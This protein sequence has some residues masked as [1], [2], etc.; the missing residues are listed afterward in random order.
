MEQPQIDSKYHKYILLVERILNSFES[1]NEWADVIAFL[2][3]LLKSFQAYPQYA[4]VPHK[5]VVAKRL[6]Q[7]L[8]PALPAG[9]HQKTLEVYEYI[10]QSIGSGQLEEDLHLYSY[11]LFPFLQNASTSVKT[12]LLKIFEKH[13]L[14]L[15]KSLSPC[16][17][18]FI[19]ALLPGLEEERTELFEKV[20]A[21][22]DK[23]SNVVGP[24][25]FYQAMWLC[26]ISAPQLRFCAIN[27]LTQRMPKI[28]SLE[29]VAFLL[30]NDTG[31]MVR[32]ISA[33][34]EDKDILVQRGILELLVNGFPLQSQIFEEENLKILMSHAVGVVLRKD[35]SLNRRLYTWLLGPGEQKQQQEYF[36]TYSKN[37]LL[38]A[39]KEMFFAE[40]A[41]VIDLQRPYKVL[42]SLMDKWEIG[43][44]I[45]RDLL[46]DILSSL[47]M[48]Y[49]GG[50]EE[51]E[52]YQTANMFISMVEPRLFWSTL[53]TSLT[54]EMDVNSSVILNLVDFIVNYVSFGDS[55]TLRIHFPLFLLVLLHRLKESQSPEGY[56]AQLPHKQSIIKTCL[57]LIKNMSPDQFREMPLATQNGSSSDNEEKSSNKESSPSP[58]IANSSLKA[59][60]DIIALAEKIYHEGRNEDDFEIIGGPSLANMALSCIHHTYNSILQ[61][62][63]SSKQEGRFAAILKELAILCL[64]I[65]DG[66]EADSFIANDHI[67]QI[68]LFC[69]QIHDLPLLDLVFT[70]LYKLVKTNRCVD[71]AQVQENMFLERFVNE[72]WEFLVPDHVW[73]HSR[74]VELIWMAHT[75]S[76]DHCLPNAV[77]KL[78]TPQ[79]IQARIKAFEIFSVFWSHSVDRHGS[80]LVLARSLLVVLGSLQDDEPRISRIA[81][82]WI[83][84]HVFA[85]QHLHQSFLEILTM[86]LLDPYLSWISYEHQ[87]G[88]YTCHFYQYESRFDEAQVAYGFHC[89]KMLWKLGGSSFLRVLRNTQVRNETLVERSKVLLDTIEELDHLSYLHIVVAASLRFLQSEF[90]TEC[91]EPVHHLNY[92]I[93][94]ACTD[95]LFLFV[96]HADE[97]DSNLACTIRDVLFRKLLQTIDARNFE[98]QAYLLPLLYIVL[99]LA[100]LSRE[101]VKKRA[102]MPQISHPANP[103][104]ET[105]E[106]DDLVSVEHED[107]AP[108]P[109]ENH[110]AAG[111]TSPHPISIFTDV[112]IDAI[113]TQFNSSIIYD[114]FHFIVVT[115]PCIDEFTT[116]VVEALINCICSQITMVVEKLQGPGQVEGLS[117]DAYSISEQIIALLEGLDKISVYALNGSVAW[118]RLFKS[119]NREPYIEFWDSPYQ[120]SNNTTAN[121][122]QKM[123]EVVL[124]KLFNIHDILY[125]TWLVVRRITQDEGKKHD[126]LVTTA[127]PSKN[128]ICSC[129]KMFLFRL[130]TIQPI[131][132]SEA[133]AGIWVL[134]NLSV[135]SAETKEPIDNTSIELFRSLP[136]AK[137][138]FVI[139]TLLE[140]VRKRTATQHKGKKANDFSELNSLAI[141]KYLESYCQMEL[142]SDASVD[143]WNYCIRFAREYF[144]NPS[145]HKFIFPHILRLLTTV[146]LKLSST[147]ISERKIHR[148]ARDVYQRI[149]D[150]SILL[151]GKLFSLGMWSRKSTREVD[152]LVDQYQLQALQTKYTRDLSDKIPRETEQFLREREIRMFQ[153]L[154]EYIATDV[155]PNLNNL[156][157]EQDRITTIF[158]NLV[159]YIISPVLKSPTSHYME[160]VLD[161]L[162][163]ASRNSSTYK[164]WRKE[165]WDY[166]MDTQFFPL[167]PELSRKWSKMIQSTISYEKER[168]AEVLGKI[169]ASP[170]ALFSSKEQE[171]LNRVQMLRRLSFIIFSGTHDQY[172]SILPTIQE[173]LVELVKS[174]AE[175]LVHVE[176]YLCLRVLLVR[177][178][179]RHL[180]NFWP[181]LLTELIR[182]FE[183]FRQKGV[184][185]SL[186]CDLMLAAC[187]FLDLVFTLGTDEF[188]IHQWIFI[189]DGVD[190]SKVSAA[191]HGLLEKIDPKISENSVEMANQE[192][193]QVAELTSTSLKS[194]RPMLHMRRITKASELSFFVKYIS[195]HVYQDTYSLNKPDISF[196]EKLIENDLIEHDE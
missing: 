148:E 57:S 145:G 26:M 79:T 69:L 117:L 86:V 116:H 51:S 61:T 48:H 27:F 189:T 112:L 24:V 164:I 141:I 80:H 50:H 94:R 152:D 162:L 25:S 183:M 19:L 72:L 179:P 78:L 119:K 104:A 98:L 76:S 31:L 90:S 137:P 147:I 157:G 21:L 15:E 108:R 114:W 154:M 47:K 139:P 64:T 9:V 49:D 55:E 110:K 83:R 124:Q 46:I 193:T 109:T 92:D 127:D 191:S 56:L 155:I 23:L 160:A 13:Y 70:F 129:L 11:G 187:K 192:L 52:L 37:I 87:H 60:E 134:N 123:R 171:M 178:A 167:Y 93:Q 169:T 73:Q 2:G 16:L 101:S 131:E 96:S 35:M 32:A 17:K 111:R 54:N 105:D 172:L 43:Y 126:G 130:Y 176:I 14:P 135:I 4:F 28:T 136:K 75:L 158:S 22:L 39:M 120:F 128:K 67:Q 65:V 185:N 82:S 175:E 74:V 144:H 113:S 103:P 42:I 18:S 34:L 85:H 161:I 159:Y 89:I 184:E 140:S 118:D 91:P 84:S 59:D 149:L 36:E 3:R 196:I 133:F 182:L 146:Y 132:V 53:Y 77:T 142:E 41:S 177:I 33:T 188:Q 168:F 38:S 138:D 40:S 151:V 95:N 195:L 106:F 1:V 62:C 88:E 7:C 12:Q 6:A 115:L 63:Q 174:N 153:N 8:N 5:L 190:V 20:V 170:S 163:A 166:F 68:K 10:F 44:F 181:V 122:R 99:N 100:P 186:Q 107:F 165:V 150:Y 102:A 71:E 30:G 29:D 81:Q 58:G 97:K 180:A 45:V 143:I 156:L 173:K 121:T 194:K 125:T 66:T